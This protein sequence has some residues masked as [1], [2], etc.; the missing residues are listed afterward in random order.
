VKWEIT[1]T[2]PVGPTRGFAIPAFIHNWQYHYSP[3]KVYGDGL[4]DCWSSVDLNILKRKLDQ[5]WVASAAPTGAHISIHNLG[6]ATV[7]NCKWECRPADLLKQVEESVSHLNPGRLGLIDLNGEE[8]VAVHGKLRR[9]KLS[10]TDGKPFRINPE[11]EEIPGESIPVFLHSDSEFYLTSWFIYKDGSSRI[12]ISSSISSLQEMATRMVDGDLCASVPDGARINIE[13][14]GWFEAQDSN[15]HVK[16]KERVR[17]AYDVRS[18]LNGEPGAIQACRVSFQEYEGQSNS[19]NR[20]RL[21]SAYEAVPE[22]LRI[23]CG[24]MDSKDRPIRKVLYADEQT[25]RQSSS[26]E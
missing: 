12:G 18:I 17:E 20:D 7:K 24:D 11:G 8:D 21:R 26:P 14:L 19:T 22:H 3:L 9:R 25:S 15:W 16:P 6:G 23:Y 2:K 10:I 5:G 4:V 1:R 13:G